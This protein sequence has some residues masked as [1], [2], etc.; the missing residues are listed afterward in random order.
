MQINI[1]FT[2]TY[3][4]KANATKAVEKK[5]PDINNMNQRWM[6]VPVELDKHPNRYGVLFI[7]TKAL[8]IGAHFHFNVVS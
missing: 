2:K 3:A 4:T 5:Y 7:G 1:E 8:D 6:I